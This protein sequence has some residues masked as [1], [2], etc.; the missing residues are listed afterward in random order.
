MGW[1]FFKFRCEAIDRNGLQINNIQE[2][3]HETEEQARR[4]LIHT[5]NSLH[6]VYPR[7]LDLITIANWEPSP[8]YFD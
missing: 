3:I 4:E 7:K 2:F 5:L 6:G 8:F 1:K